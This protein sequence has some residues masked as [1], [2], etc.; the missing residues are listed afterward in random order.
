LLAF[1]YIHPV[2]IAPIIG[3]TK[4]DRIDSAKKAMDINLSREDF[5]KLWQASTGHE[6]A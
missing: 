1:L 3:T 6:V 2:N 4:F 5:Y